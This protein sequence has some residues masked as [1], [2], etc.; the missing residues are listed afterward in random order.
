MESGP[1]KRVLV[2]SSDA[3]VAGALA[4]LL[5]GLPGLPA[6]T[7]EG[8]P[9]E[10]DDVIATWKP[11]VAIVD[12]STSGAAHD[13]RALGRLTRRIPVVAVCDCEDLRNLAIARGVVHCCDKSGDI[14]GLTNAVAA[15]AETHPT[16][17][18]T[19]A[20]SVLGSEPPLAQSQ[21][22][23]QADASSCS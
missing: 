20:E 21:R 23:L 6:E 5:S 11:D 13:L 16:G 10:I 3:R 18:S 19:S 4:A 22:R 2:V 12:L 14:E 17:R 8:A 15:A 7:R 1:R 9:D